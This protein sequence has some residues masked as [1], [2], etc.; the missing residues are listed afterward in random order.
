[1]E[2][3]VLRKIRQGV[4]Y[5]FAVLLLV[6]FLLVLI[7][8]IIHTWTVTDKLLSFAPTKKFPESVH[9]KFDRDL[10]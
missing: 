5:C 4:L 10:G 1:M 8:G 3:G 7:E 6:A 9:T 2:K